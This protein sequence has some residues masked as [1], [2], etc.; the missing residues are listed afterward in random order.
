[1]DCNTPG[2]PVLHCLPEFAQIHVHW[3]GEAIQPS[4]PLSP[5]FPSTLNR[6]QQQGLFQW[7]SSLHWIH[8]GIGASALASVLPM[9]I[10]GW[11]PL[12]LTGLISLQSKG[13]SRVFSSTIV[14]KYQF[15]IAQLSLWSNSRIC[16]WLLEKSQLWLY[17]LLSSKLRPLLL[18]MLSRF[19]IA[20]LPRSKHLWILW[21][22]SLST[23]IL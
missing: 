11:C 12:R 22:Q 2:F 20:F 7:V 18:N 8:Q 19:V 5:P 10:Q 14:W 15:F 4:H 16:T 9:Y 17:G 1:M 21:L 13:L 3:V 6:S 23:V